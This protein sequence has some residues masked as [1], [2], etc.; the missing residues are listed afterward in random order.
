[1]AEG[2]RT[3]LDAAWRREEWAELKV[4]EARARLSYARAAV[5]AR[6]GSGMGLDGTPPTG[7]PTRFAADEHRALGEAAAQLD[8]AE[9]A[10]SRA[11]L[12]R[13]RLRTVLSRPKGRR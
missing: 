1:M 7:I 3:R 2:P 6:N 10:L 13:R 8:L 9:A 12:E 5:V 11:R 4:Y